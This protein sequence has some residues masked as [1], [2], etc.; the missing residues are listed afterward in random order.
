METT[1]AGKL[2]ALLQF[3]AA[4]AANAPDLPHIEGARVRL[5]RA[6]TEA[7]EISKQQAALAASKQEASKRLTTLLEEGV[8]LATAIRKLLGDNYGIRS[9]KLT[10]FGLQPF[11]GRMAKKGV[12]VKPEPPAPPAAPLDT[13]S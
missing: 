7:Q 1:K 3:N 5:E 8:R 12:V 4:L 10:E 9:E 2:G 13:N 6:L 11:R